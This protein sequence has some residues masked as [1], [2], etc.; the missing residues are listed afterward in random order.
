MNLLTSETVKFII[1]IIKTLWSTVNYVIE[2]SYPGE[3]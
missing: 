1:T 2:Y 3:M